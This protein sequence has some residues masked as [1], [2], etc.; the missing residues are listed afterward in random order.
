LHQIQQL[1]TTAAIR[2]FGASSRVDER[3]KSVEIAGQYFH[4]RR[5]RQQR[6]SAAETTAESAANN[7]RQQLQQERRLILSQMRAIEA[8]INNPL[9]K[10]ILRNNFDSVAKRSLYNTLQDLYQELQTRLKRIPVT[11]GGS[12]KVRHGRRR[13]TKRKKKRRRRKTIKR[14]RKRGRKTRRK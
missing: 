8:I 10:N 4:A 12:R 13:K 1:R 5:K 9:N 11:G 3:D 14:R 6:P 7:A 2:S